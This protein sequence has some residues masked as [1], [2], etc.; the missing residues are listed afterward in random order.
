MAWAF[1]DDEQQ[2]DLEREREALRALRAGPVMP[3]SAE[4]VAYQV[5]VCERHV[6]RWEPDGE[7][8]A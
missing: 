4:K 3:D 7:K 8:A 2:A 1:L 5:R 6:T